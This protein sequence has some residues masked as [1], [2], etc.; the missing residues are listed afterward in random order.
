[1]AQIISISNQ[2]GGVGKTTTSVNLAASLA[3]AEKSCLLVDCDPQ[4]N[5]TT[6]VGVDRTD[7]KGGL[8]DLLLGDMS[9]DDVIVQTEVPGLHLVGADRDLVGAEVEL[10]ALRDKE[11]RLKRTLEDLRGRYNF[12]FL[13][14][15]P[16]F[17]Y[18]TVNAL[19][20]ADS[21]L[22]PLQCEYYA[23]EG[24]SQLIN[25]IRAVKKS[26]NPALRLM[27]ILLTMSDMRN[28]LSQQVAQEVRAH[29]G[30]SVFKTMIPRNV[31]LSEAPS[32][33][34]PILLYD[35]RSKGAQSY[36]ELAREFIEKGAG[37]H[38]KAK[39]TG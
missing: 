9:P 16:S 33:G 37:N 12:I 4:G 32:H 19:T 38:D 25:T 31:R 15:P 27:G 13:D 24:L 10:I 6:G 23:L 7:L 29:F 14:C 5:A 17:G 26:L 36:L 22:V 20:A 35:I 18:L 2:K 28:N 1:M 30:K 34:K 39:G 3:A 21:V 11:F 8:Y